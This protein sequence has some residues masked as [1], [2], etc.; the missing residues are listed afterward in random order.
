MRCS[1]FLDTIPHQEGHQ[2]IDRLTISHQ[3][4]E[5]K[6]KR[7]SKD[8]H[9]AYERVRNEETNSICCCIIVLRYHTQ[10]EGRQEIDRLA[11]S[12]QLCEDKKKKQGLAHRLLYIIIII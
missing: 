10:Q 6:N 5:D 11:I 9:I 3:L 8:W 12:H 4:C 1:K 7:K 2:E